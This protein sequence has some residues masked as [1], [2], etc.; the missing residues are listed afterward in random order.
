MENKNDLENII[1]NMG[2]KFRNIDGKEL[3]LSIAVDENKNVLMTAFMDKE[4]IKM[5]IKTGFMHYFSTSRNK[6]W[7]KGEE[8][9]NVQKVIDVFKDCDGD[10]LL[11]VVKQT[12]WACHEGYMSCFHNKVDLNSGNSIV[13]GDKLD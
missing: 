2:L 13:I 7:M 5:T 3:L 11:F 9:S 10:A 12:G 4:S 1:K 6:L 8:S